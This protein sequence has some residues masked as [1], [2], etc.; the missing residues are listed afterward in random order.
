MSLGTSLLLLHR[1]YRAAADK[2]VLHVGMSQSMAYPLIVIGR[3]GDGLSTGALA[4]AIGIE[5]P[6]L[7]RQ[8]DYLVAAGM[9][10][11][12]TDALDRRMKTLHLMPAGEAAREEIEVAL[13]VMRD[14]LFQGIGDGDVQACLRVFGI[15]HA[16]LDW[17]NRGGG[18][19]AG[20][21]NDVLK[22][23]DEIR[24]LQAAADSARTSFDPN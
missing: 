3:R 4:E 12:R 13:A 19:G 5:S 8:L 9:V 16:R 17:P 2:A 14:R 11:R 7:V 18:V 22:A 1:A 20:K 6:S 23:D 15:L 21:S 24:P 10:E